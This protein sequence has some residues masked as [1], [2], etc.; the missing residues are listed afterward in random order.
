[1]GDV[2]WLKG[3]VGE[4]QPLHMKSQEWDLSVVLSGTG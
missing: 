4:R 1:M 3:L 2:L